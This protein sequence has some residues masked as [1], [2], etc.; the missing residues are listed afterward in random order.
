MSVS[1]SSR[2]L[3]KS[4]VAV[5][6]LL[7]ASGSAA[8]LSVSIRF[9]DRQLYFTDS[10]IEVH[11][12][13]LNDTA[14]T[15]RFRLADERVFSMDFQV[16]TTTNRPVEVSPQFTTERSANQVFYREVTLEPGEELSFVEPLNRYVDL[17]DPGAYL[18]TA[19]FYPDL[20]TTPQG[21]FLRSNTLTLS[22]RPG[23]GTPEQM[24]EAAL[25]VATEETLRR[26]DVPPDQVIR[27]MLD[28]RI[29]ENWPRFFL[30]IDLE[31]LYRQNAA[32]ERRYLAMSE[33][34]RI[35]TV[36]RFRE[37]LIAGALN[38]EIIT[39]PS[40]Y[41]ILETTYT[42]AAGE[43]V[44]RQRFDYPAFSETKRYRYALERR[45]GFWRITGYTV[46]NVST[47]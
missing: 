38:E 18:V 40:E 16:R 11:T 4:A 25:T 41:E 6:L 36:E 44:V 8:A 21:D 22:I 7:L 47:N 43:V 10:R 30:Y 26:E 1:F 3:M 15:V 39:V 28:A 31:A 17:Q 9:Y 37:Q 29:R 32:R 27:F 45:G 23:R 24:R 12:T 14:E 19:R 13:L 2:S 46:V 20:F 33:E 42:P 5:L 35:E 34:E